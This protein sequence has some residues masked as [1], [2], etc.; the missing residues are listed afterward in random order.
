MTDNTQAVL[1]QFAALAQ[2]PDQEIDVARAAFLIAATEY[3]DLDIEGQVELLDSLAAG[4]SRRLGGGKDSLFY[5]NTLAEYLFDEVGFRGNHEDYYDPDNSF[6]NQVLSRRLGIPI[7]LSLLCSEVGKRIGIPLVGIGMPGHFLL[8]HQN[9]GDLFLDP[10]NRGILLSVNECAER[11]NDV[12]RGNI[13]WDPAFLAPVGNRDFVARIIRNLKGIYLNGAD[14]VRAIRMMDLLVALLPMEPKERRDR[15]L[16]HFEL[17]HW[18]EAKEDL[19]RY[20]DSGSPKQ[21]TAAVN[22]MLGRID[23]NQPR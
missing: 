2:V 20:L 5:L 1:G 22:W 9:E 4:V 19:R 11:L 12:A 10:F 23:A 13:A 16:I 18:E 8:R 15:G 7:T 3:P 21:D 14:H 17:E 6:L